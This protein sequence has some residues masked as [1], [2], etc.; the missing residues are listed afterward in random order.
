MASLLPIYYINLAA[1][2]DRRAAMEAQFDALGLP[3]IRIDAVTPATLPPGAIGQYGDPRR[4]HWM[5]PT[6]LSCSFSHIATLEQLLASGAPHGV[7]FEDDVVLSPALPHFLAAFAAAPPP[8]DLVRL[9]TFDEPL[10]LDRAIDGQVGGIALRKSYSWAAG[11]AGYLMSRRGAGI[12]LASSAIRETQVD[13][14]LFNPYE[15]LAR[16]ISMRH[17]DPGLCIQDSRLPGAATAASSIAAGRKGR[18]AIEHDYRWARLGHDL[19]HW[20][21][22]ELRVGPLKIWHQTVGGAAKRHIPFR[23]EP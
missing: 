21:D 14:A 7:V 13:R 22:R 19:R 1:R 10:R 5:M 11:S 3:A 12:V 15:P 9:E 20:L 18:A 17:A 2:S 16:R 6:E 23:S 4:F 8:F